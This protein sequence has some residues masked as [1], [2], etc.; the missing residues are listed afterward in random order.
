MMQHT[1]HIHQQILKYSMCA[2]DNGPSTGFSRP[3]RPTDDDEGHHL[4]LLCFLAMY[5]RSALPLI[6]D[7]AY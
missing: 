1:F 5:N 2:R 6:R 7:S 4:T 3:D